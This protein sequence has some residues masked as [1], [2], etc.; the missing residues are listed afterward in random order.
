MKIKVIIL[1]IIM[2][3]IGSLS[4]QASQ[5]PKNIKDYLLTGQKVPSI[6][7]DG[8]VV[9]NENLLYIPVIP[10]YPKV[11]EKLEIVKTIPEN[12][13][14]S[15]FPDLVLFNN[16]YALLKVTRIDKNTLAVKNIADLPE[17]VKTGAI[18]QDMMV[19][20]GLVI[21]ESYA[22]ILGDVRIP[23]IG[24]A[25]SPTFVTGRMALPLP[26]GKRL[27]AA[28]RMYV[29]QALKN[30]LFFVN[31]FQTEYLQI[32]SA[33]V[34]EPLYSLKTS[35]VMKDIKSAMGGKYILAA[36]NNQKNI[37]VIDIANECISKHITLTANPSEIAIDE[38]NKKAYVAS[39]EDE[40][41]FVIDL[42]SM[43]LKE[44]I[45]LVGAPQ[46]LSISKEGTYLAYTDM[47]TSNVYILD[48]VNGYENKLITNYPNITKMILDNDTIYMIAR[49]KPYLRI[50][51]FDLLQDNKVSKTKKDRKN[52]KKIKQ[53]E[54]ESIDSETDDIIGSFD[55][56]EVEEDE[57]LKDVKTYSTG[58]KEIE[59]GKKPVDMAERNGIIYVLCADNNSVYN[60]DAKKE[61]VSV[62]K[63]PVNGFSKSFTLIPNSN[64]AVVTNMAEL[65][66]VV[67][68]TERNKPIQVQP[69]SEYI[70]MI[71]VLERKNG[72]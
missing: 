62:E 47:K 70:N 15:A 14:M 12:K 59:V 57:T 36:T 54:K 17:E 7:F 4:V 61:T 68:D 25:K 56:K 29:P 43:T 19:P 10:A 9:Y 51:T 1:T 33:S 28:K 30:K 22:G 37:D 53:E 38:V 34:S 26:D 71:T 48:L 20:R 46:R 32:F 5:L 6:R 65:K 45:Q 31:N 67:Y 24:S 3:L 13:T 63:L 50:V 35:G 66:Y 23:L 64:F 39:I 16:N 55:Y 52:D 69:I 44:K 40:S 21:P 18:P 2:L 58:I 60:V 27:S 42:S 72:Q 11:V 41:L 49:T 8:I